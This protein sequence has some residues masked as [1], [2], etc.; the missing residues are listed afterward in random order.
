MHAHDQALL[1]LKPYH[2]MQDQGS[3]DNVSIIIADL[4]YASVSTSMIA[5]MI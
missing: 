3:Q 5:V 2:T 1:T 4:G